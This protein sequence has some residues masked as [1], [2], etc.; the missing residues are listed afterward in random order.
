M[1]KMQKKF[2]SI[3]VL[4]SLGMSS[5]FLSYAAAVFTPDSQPIGYVAQNEITR[6]NVAS[7]A[8]KLFSAD[9]DNTNWTGNLHSFNVNSGGGV[10]AADNWV[11][12]AT[13]AIDLQNFD[14][15]R[16]I[17]TQNAAGTNVGF[18]WANFSAAEQTTLVSQNVLN[19]V[20][21]DNAGEIAGTYRPRA[22]KLGDIIHSTPVYSNAGGVNTVF[23][24]A[25]DGMLHAINAADGSERWAY[26]PKVL[27]PKLD[28]L[29]SLT[30]SHK[31]YVDG[32]IDVGTYTSSGVAKTILVGATGAGG[33]GLFA[34]DVSNAAFD[35][36]TT[37]ASKVLWDIN[38]STAG[39]A[40]L[41]Y[42]YA[43]P[44]L[45]RL[46]DG[47]SGVT[48][49]RPV[50]IVGNGY[51]NT[52]NGHASLFII[53]ALNGTKYKEIDTGIGSAGS[54]N[55]LSTPS[56]F[57]EN[58]DG[59]MDYA[60]AGD[61]DG[62]LWRFDLQ[63]GTKKK[64]I[65][66]NPV[67]AI[68]MAPG[69]LRNPAG[70]RVITFVTGRMLTSGDATDTATHYAYGVMDD[71]L[72]SNT[73]I[74]TQTLTETNFAGIT[75]N[76]PT[77]KASANVIDW[78]AGGDGGWKTALPVGGERVVGDG[79]YVADGIF[80]FNTTNPTANA[81]LNPPGA[82]WAMQLN[83]LTGGS[84][85][86]IRFDLNSDQ[87]FS[88][89]DKSSDLSI[90]VGRYLGAGVRSQSITMFSNGVDIYSNNLDTN[91]AIG[92]VDNGHFDVDRYCGASTAI[93]LGFALPSCQHIHQYD[94]KYLATGVN[95]L[96]AGM[97][98]LNLS[99]NVAPND[100]TFTTTTGFKLLIANQK[101][102]PA[103]QFVI[104]GTTDN[105]RKVTTYGVETSAAAV[106]AAAPIYT[107]ANMN[108]F[109]F[110]MPADALDTKEW[111]AGDSRPGLFP[112]VTGCVK[113]G[114]AGAAGEWRSG[115]LT[116][117]L[118]R[119][120]VTAADIELNLAATPSMG[121]RLKPTRANMDNLLLAEYTVFWHADEPSCYGGGNNW[122]LDP[123]R[124]TSTSSYV[125]NPA[126]GHDPKRPIVDP[127]VPPSTST[128]NNPIIT[129][130]SNIG[131]VNWR[132]L[133]K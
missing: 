71:D 16:I 28:D 26:I 114:S 89:T 127:V 77:R 112:T 48:N 121:W 42:T 80:V 67:Q 51:N 13:A 21:G 57:D 119:D 23:V 60:Y 31:Y 65:T 1:M 58:K 74:K 73:A 11:G 50:V 124:D 24:G 122:T 100:T 75:P 43:A 7:G 49:G 108:R 12:G 109:K 47:S 94:D 128:P 45:A 5:Y 97:P 38:N 83:A 98:N 59:R 66:T 22:H 8:E 123:G 34:I 131:R 62:N 105:Y 91:V 130:Q 102:N 92:G 53:D 35:S 106:L 19:Y 18:R 29:S 103:V 99:R 68:T 110:N 129:P 4:A 55:G 27:H 113:G 87:I 37:A 95:M 96:D 133:R 78:A 104:G 52:G 64:L 39:Y 9:Y 6:S 90:P 70:G 72:K 111:V 44:T 25:N 116:F 88:A 32:R 15:G 81:T 40:N 93:S 125:G 76:I 101:F 107:Y 84:V 10:A 117:Q 2:L 79:A 33:T 132:E 17:F 82:N 120:T 56:L 69:I 3:A 85:G 86:Q 54:P 30:Y 20:R 36:E 41:G 61:L 115:A 118:V 46:P 63:A 126:V 14:T